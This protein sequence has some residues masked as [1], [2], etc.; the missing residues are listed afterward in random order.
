MMAR[1][2]DVVVGDALYLDAPFINFCL[3][4]GNTRS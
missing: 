3:E 1:F 2:F 4:H